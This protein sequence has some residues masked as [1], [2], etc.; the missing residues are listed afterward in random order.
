MTVLVPGEED[1]KLYRLKRGGGGGG[2]GEKLKVRSI[3]DFSIRFR[4]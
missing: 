4:F 3:I 1:S 2:R